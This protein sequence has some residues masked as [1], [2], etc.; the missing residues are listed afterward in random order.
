MSFGWDSIL[1]SWQSALG[2]NHGSG[3]FIR[4]NL[5]CCHA[6]RQRIYLGELTQILIVERTHQA[7]AS[8]ILALKKHVFDCI[9]PTIQIKT[10]VTL[11]HFFYEHSLENKKLCFH[12][13]RPEWVFILHFLNKLLHH[14]LLFSHL[15]WIALGG[16][17]LRESLLLCFFEMGIFCLF[18]FCL[19]IFAIESRKWCEVR[20]CSSI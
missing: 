13:R 7:I 8:V 19:Q 18:L 6:N 12:L 15:N 11:T 9:I 4:D 5:W 2:S 3:V 20:N 16:R 10:K 1:V 14:Y 17:S